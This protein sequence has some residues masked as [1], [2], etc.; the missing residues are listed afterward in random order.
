MNPYV[1]GPWLTEDVDVS[2]PSVSPEG[3]ETT[4]EPEEKK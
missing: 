4:P 3:D 1:D 2:L